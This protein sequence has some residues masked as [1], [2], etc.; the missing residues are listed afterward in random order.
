ML[1]RQVRGFSARVSQI[2]AVV[3]LLVMATLLAGLSA[4]PAAAQSLAN[5]QLCE[6]TGAE[7]DCDNASNPRVGDVVHYRFELANG[8]FQGARQHGLLI[9]VRHAGQ[10]TQ[11]KHNHQ[12]PDPRHGQPRTGRSTLRMAKLD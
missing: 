3:A 8:P 6:D 9:G 5:K 7:E 12:P 11:P 10:T 2:A 4:T 1:V